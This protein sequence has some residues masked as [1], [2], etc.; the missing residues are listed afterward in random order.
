MKQL[1]FWEFTYVSDI[2]KF[3]GQSEHIFVAVCDK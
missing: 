3:P 2:L 1:F